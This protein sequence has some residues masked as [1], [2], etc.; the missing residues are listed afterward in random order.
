[1]NKFNFSIISIWVLIFGVG[2]NAGAVWGKESGAQRKV[3]EY[4]ERKGAGLAACKGDRACLDRVRGEQARERARAMRDLMV[5]I[6]MSK[7][8]K[9]MPKGSEAITSDRPK[10][11]TEQKQGS[12]SEAPKKDEFDLGDLDF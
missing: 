7:F 2:L 1:M 6:D 12:S 11:S 5:P 4:Y 10:N 9:T 3:R 8:K